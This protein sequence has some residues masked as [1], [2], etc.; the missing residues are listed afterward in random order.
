MLSSHHQT[1]YLTV[2]LVLAGVY[3]MWMDVALYI[4][5]QRLPSLPP[6]QP[7]PH[8][9]KADNASS[10]VIVSPSSSSSTI[11]SFSP[12]YPVRLKLLMT[13][14]VDHYVVESLGHW[15]VAYTGLA[16]HVTANAVS[17]AG[18]VLAL[19]GCRLV[20]SDCL[21]TR[22]L[23]VLFM[24]LRDYADSL[25]GWVARARDHHLGFKIN[26]EGSGYYMDGICDGVAYFVYFWGL[27]VHLYKSNAFYNRCHRG[28]TYWRLEAAASIATGPNP[29]KDKK[30]KDDDDPKMA[31]DA[32]SASSCHHD[33]GKVATRY[34]GMQRKASTRAR[35][36]IS[37]SLSL[38]ALSQQVLPLLPGVPALRTA[39]VALW[40]L[41][42]HGRPGVPQTARD[43][44]GGQVRNRN[45]HLSLCPRGEWGWS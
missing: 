10:V 6:L 16:S 17:I 7:S 23:G 25:D 38:Q 30:K 41:L 8:L 21:R 2:L 19:V 27:A 26:T 22:Q 36:L 9:D 43:V 24:F 18:V 29:I 3:F 45:P 5:L 40:R 33:E 13:G 12:V 39:G 42:E 1:S 37:A 14:P 28:D 4:N 20:A 11:T 15:T 32:A 34:Q 31:S 35:R 44:R